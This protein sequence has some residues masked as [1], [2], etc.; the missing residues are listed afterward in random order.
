MIAGMILNLLSDCKIRLYHLTRF[1]EDK[2]MPLLF[3]WN[4]DVSAEDFTEERGG[5]VLDELFQ[6]NPQKVFSILTHHNIKLYGINSSSIRVDTTS[7]IVY[8]RRRINTQNMGAKVPNNMLSDLSYI[9]NPRI[10][11]S[12]NVW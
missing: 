3:P 9:Y 12:R 1:F 7:D 6:A 5:N 10:R 11:C 4:P 8:L 2:P